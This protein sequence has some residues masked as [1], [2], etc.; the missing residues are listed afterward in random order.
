MK[1]YQSTESF[2]VCIRRRDESGSDANSALEAR[3]PKGSF[4]AYEGLF[5]VGEGL[6]EAIAKYGH[7]FRCVIEPVESTHPFGGECD[8][9]VTVTGIGFEEDDAQFEGVCDKCGENLTAPA[10]PGK[11]ER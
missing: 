2:Y 9:E 5:E 3:W 6:K 4:G 1:L 11:W 10:H 7:E 8:H